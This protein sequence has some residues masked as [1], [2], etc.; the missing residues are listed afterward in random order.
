M[1]EK[2]REPEVREARVPVVEC[3]DGLVR[4]TL[5]ELASTHS[6]KS[7]TLQNACSTR[8]RVVA[9]LEKIARMPFVRLMKGPKRMM[10][11]SQ[12]EEV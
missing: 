3:L 1:S 7:G 8:L 4:I 5:K 11:N 9:C 10:T 6:V 12:V 2:R